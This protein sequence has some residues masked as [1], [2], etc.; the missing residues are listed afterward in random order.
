MNAFS[1]TYIYCTT[2]LLFLKVTLHKKLTYLS[3]FNTFLFILLILL[4][5]TLIPLFQY[6]RYPGKHNKILTEFRR[7]FSLRRVLH[8][9]HSQEP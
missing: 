4:L 7:T 9:L 5:N 3:V 2:F 8:R 1:I 6:P